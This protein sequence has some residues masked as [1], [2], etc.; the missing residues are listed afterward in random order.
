MKI[1]KIISFL[2]VIVFCGGC[3]AKRV[4]SS[5]SG[6]QVP[7]L[8]TASNQPGT[9]LHFYKNKNVIV[10]AE[11]NE[12]AV[13][14]GYKLKGHSAATDGAS[15]FVY[16]GNLDIEQVCTFYKKALEIGGWIYLDLST[17]KEGLLAA[18]RAL[19]KCVISVRPVKQNS[20]TIHIFIQNKNNSN[21]QNFVDLNKI[22]G[23]R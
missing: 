3:G 5:H 19:K 9:K 15:L 8:E 2:S 10:E 22:N 17:K 12:L 20:S 4:I 7:A 13:P 6:S 1:Y 21:R 16:T 18:D 14:V 23:A 11:Q